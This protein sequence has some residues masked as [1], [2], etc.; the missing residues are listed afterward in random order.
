MKYGF[1]W[2]A[3]STWTVLPFLPCWSRLHLGDGDV[4]DV[5]RFPYQQSTSVDPCLKNSEQSWSQVYIRNMALQHRHVISNIKPTSTG[6]LHFL[7]SCSISIS[8][9]LVKCCIQP[10]IV[11]IWINSILTTVMMTSFSN[12]SISHIKPNSNVI[13]AKKCKCSR[14]VLSSVKKTR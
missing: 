7:M 1:Q 5:H 9:R 6:S 3:T 2:Q 10:T 14:S 4:G 11:W 8:I 12:S 13:K